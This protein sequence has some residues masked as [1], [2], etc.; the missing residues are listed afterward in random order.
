MQFILVYS[1]FVV[2]MAKFFCRNC[3][4]FNLYKQ[5]LRLLLL[6]LQFFA[7]A[8]KKQLTHTHTHTYMYTYIFFG[9]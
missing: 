9:Q 5:F 8:T 2:L 1:D 7:L 4:L 3:S 6:L